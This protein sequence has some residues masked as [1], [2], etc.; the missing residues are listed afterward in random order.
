MTLIPDVFPQILA[1]KNMIRYMS[2]KPCFG[3]PLDRQH[4]KW[5]NTL[6]QSE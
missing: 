6:L 5:G 1:P 4:G 2:K 3:V